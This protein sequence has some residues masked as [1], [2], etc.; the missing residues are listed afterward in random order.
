[1]LVAGYF[2]LRRGKRLSPGEE[3][4][5][6]RQDRTPDAHARTVGNRGVGPQR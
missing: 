2:I 3:L 1:M 5:H 6:L 4:R